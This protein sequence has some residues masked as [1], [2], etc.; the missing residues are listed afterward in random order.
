MLVFR[1]NIKHVFSCLSQL[2]YYLWTTSLAVYLRFINTILIQQG[3]SFTQ[4]SQAHRKVQKPLPCLSPHYQ[5]LKTNAGAFCLELKQTKVTSDRHCVKSTMKNRWIRVGFF[6]R[7]KDDCCKPKTS[8]EYVLYRRFLLGQRLGD[9]NVRCDSLFCLTWLVSRCMGFYRQAATPR[10]AVLPGVKASITF[11]LQTCV[12]LLDSGQF[13]ITAAGVVSLSQ[14][15]RW[16]NKFK[17]KKKACL[18][19]FTN[20]R[21]W[22]WSAD[23]S[24]LLVLLN[25]WP[26]ITRLDVFYPGLMTTPLERTS[27][28]NEGLAKMYELWRVKLE[29][30]SYRGS[31][32]VKIQW[33]RN[34]L[35]VVLYY[36]WVEWGSSSFV[37]F[38]IS[39][40]GF[41][42]E[43]VY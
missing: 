28:S 18:F 17:F 27:T 23:E 33:Q 2:F 1:S 38:P 8:S 4:K 14:K 6:G 5:I 24:S 31:G 11:H 30:T 21:R 26:S 32:A 39:V 22:S 35:F 36:C 42:E 19:C 10:G 13:S 15:I 43:F 16:R 3:V 41:L 12:W 34:K 20:A 29:R 7:L 9:S 37:V 40:S 25:N